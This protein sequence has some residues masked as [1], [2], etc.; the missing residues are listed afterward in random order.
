MNV[1][2]LYFSFSKDKAFY[3]GTPREGR[4]TREQEDEGEEHEGEECVPSILT[5]DIRNVTLYC[6]L[7]V[8]FIRYTF[9]IDYISQLQLSQGTSVKET[10]ANFM[11]RFFIVL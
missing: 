9:C 10:L 11:V 8:L 7:Y 5:P 3:V 4:P 2:V 6:I 1:N